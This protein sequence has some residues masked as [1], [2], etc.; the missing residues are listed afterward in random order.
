MLTLAR[1]VRLCSCTCTLILKAASPHFCLFQNKCIC[2]PDSCLICNTITEGEAANVRPDPSPASG[3]TFQAIIN[4][5]ISGQ[6]QTADLCCFQFPTSVT[7]LCH[8]ATMK[9]QFTPAL[10]KQTS[11]QLSVFVFSMQCA[12][13]DLLPCKCIEMEG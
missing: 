3:T 4:V 13:V 2:C 12:A 1:V 7:R 8:S 10:I 5:D 6:H 9:H 11:L